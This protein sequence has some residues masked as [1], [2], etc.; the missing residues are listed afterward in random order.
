MERTK[1]ANLGGYIVP[2]E[3]TVETSASD[4]V[5]FISP[6]DKN[7]IGVNWG[8]HPRT[9]Y[10]TLGHN[11]IAQL[12]YDKESP[13]YPVITQSPHSQSIISTYPTGASINHLFSVPN[14]CCFPPLAKSRFFVPSTL[15][16][17]RCCRVISED[18][19][20]SMSAQCPSH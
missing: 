13:F 9:G 12:Y 5:E 19:T 2:T 3:L 17:K 4:F 16:N 11:I 7:G 15:C 8:V 1:T 10:G 14:R 6:G 20:L 18:L